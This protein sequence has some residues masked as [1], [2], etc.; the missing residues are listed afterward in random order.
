MFNKEYLDLITLNKFKIYLKLN[1][2]V[3]N[4][5]FPNKN[6][7]VFNKTYD[8]TE[9]DIVIP[10]KETFKDFKSRLY[11]SINILAD[12]E[13][14]ENMAIIH[15]ILQGKPAIKDI[16]S[17]RLISNDTENGTIP[18]ET[19][20]NAIYGIKR[21]ITSAILNENNPKPFI[22]GITNGLSDNLKNYSLGQTDIG[23]YIFNIEIENSDCE[24][25]FLNNNGNLITTSRERRVISRIQNGI[26]D[27]INIKNNSELKDI[28]PYE[29]KEGLNANMCDALLQF[30]DVDNN[31]KIETS[32]TWGSN[33]YIPKDVPQS[34]TLHPKDFFTLY[35]ISSEYKEIKPEI[36]EIV[37]DIISLFHEK[38]ERIVTINAKYKNSKK[39]FKISMNDSDYIKTCNAHAEEKQ[40]SIKGE[41]KKNGRFTYLQNYFDLIILDDSTN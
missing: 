22:K 3:Q 6:L 38:D 26:N 35:E 19:A 9:F 1:N 28:I 33:T 10:S 11:D 7:L 16:F 36:V 4:I 17:I 5:N 21:L 14:V 12:L 25:V 8:D 34:I 31:L 40:L 27:I 18:L 41:L 20:H 15:E 24:Q 30:S 37:G 39:K 29:Y 23:S 13:E 2:W 32:I